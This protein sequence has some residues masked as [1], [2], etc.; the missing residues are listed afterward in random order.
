MQVL[1]LI[2]ELDTEG[3]QRGGNREKR[4]GGK[5][6]NSGK[7]WGM[8][9][10]PPLSAGIVIDEQTESVRRHRS[11]FSQI[12]QGSLPWP[13]SW[14]SSSAIKKKD[15][16]KVRIKAALMKNAVSFLRYAMIPP[17]SNRNNNR[18]KKAHV[19]KAV[20]SPVSDQRQFLQMP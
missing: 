6:K 12:G 16:D 10:D 2:G 14:D 1:N 11:I 18:N 7:R 19:L 5:G 3:D 20:R 8:E 15:K 13:W 4:N 17:F 9:T